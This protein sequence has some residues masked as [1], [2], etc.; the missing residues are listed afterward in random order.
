MHEAEFEVMSAG[1]STR[2]SLARSLVYLVRFRFRIA[3]ESGARS[4]SVSRLAFRI[5]F[6]SVCL[7]SYREDESDRRSAFRVFRAVLTPTLRVSVT[8]S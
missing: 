4:R 3:R 8:T 5:G 7:F 2:D 6:H 1:R